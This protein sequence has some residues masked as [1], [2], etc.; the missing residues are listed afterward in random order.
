M[1]LFTALFTLSAFASTDG[2]VSDFK[3][4]ARS[5]PAKLLSYGY[6]QLGDVNTEKLL[7]DIDSVPVKIV[8]AVGHVM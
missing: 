2:V 4:N 8:G 6:R 3:Q 7:R 5:V 1:I